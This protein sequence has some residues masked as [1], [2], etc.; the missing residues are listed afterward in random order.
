MA[1]THDNSLAA[2]C[3]VISS[4]TS[5]VQIAGIDICSEAIPLAEVFVEP[6][7][8][9]S[10]RPKKI[11]H[12]PPGSEPEGAAEG[13]EDNS[14][15][16]TALQVL[17]Q[18]QQLVILGEPGQGKTTVL[19]QYATILSREP[20]GRVP[21]LVELKQLREKSVGS[22]SHLDW[23][24]ARLPDPLQEHTR[25]HSECRNSLVKVLDKGRG[26]VLL[27]GLDELTLE[28]QQQVQ[29]LVPGLV[30]CGNQVVVSSR[31]GAY[32]FTPFTGF[33]PYYLQELTV[34]QIE[35]LATSLCGALAL[36]FGLG[37]SNP[38]VQCVMKASH[39]PAAALTRNPLLLSFLCLTAIERQ[40]RNELSDFPHSA[41]QLIRGCLDAVVAWH[42]R[43]GPEAWPQELQA[44]DI[45]RILGPLALAAY[46]N[47]SRIIKQEY[48]APRSTRAPTISS[49]EKEVFFNYL[50]PA[51]L[52]ERRGG[53]YAFPLE[54]LGEYFAA[55]AVADTDTPFGC[56]RDHLHDPAW[57]RVILLTAGCLEGGH[58]NFL[59]RELP[60]LTWWLRKGFSALASIVSALMPKGAKEAVEQSGG[61]L[62][63]PL[64]RWDAR[65]R[66]S[67]EF[68]VTS[69]FRHGYQLWPLWERRNHYERVLLRDLRIATRCLGMCKDPA[70]KLV[71]ELIRACLARW[72]EWW[73]SPFLTSIQEA[74]SA[75]G[76]RAFLVEVAR[77][78]SDGGLAHGALE[79][80]ETSAEQPEVMQCVLELVEGGEE[81][82]QYD[83]AQ[84]LAKASF[85]PSFRDRLLELT[86]NSSRT[87]REA[88]ILALKD[89]VTDSRIRERILAMLEDKDRVV[90][91]TAAYALRRAVAEPEIRKLM[92][93]FAHHRD[94]YFRHVAVG[95]LSRLGPDSEALKCILRLAKDPGDPWVQPE[96]VRAL[97]AVAENPHVRTCLRRIARGKNSL[98][99]EEAR[100][101]LRDSSR[102]APLQEKQQKNIDDVLREVENGYGELPDD[103]EETISCALKLT[104]DPW[105]SKYLVRSLRSFADRPQVARRLMQLTAYRGEGQPEYANA[106][107]R[108][109]A[110]WA[111]EV[112][113]CL[114][115]VWHHLLTLAQDQSSDM[116]EIAARALRGAARSVNRTMLEQVAPLAATS[117]SAWE[118]VDILVRA[119]EER[120]SSMGM[121]R[122]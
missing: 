97:S 65:S 101:L 7:L 28:A 92:L 107:V 63:G 55:R 58:A 116:N 25:Q 60:T 2:Y 68:F 106:E 62:E 37:D 35:L 75:P 40:T 5:S 21:V 41:A 19:R 76:V 85:N 71:R 54:T 18:S 11:Q 22:G 8:S 34:E 14:E 10:P 114:P 84:V 45:V 12:E 104:C 67:T 13:R 78:G 47:G 17:R 15:T 69:I 51:R 100:R 91:R 36:Q 33:A 99:A 108:T 43:R 23:L 70:P 59:I 56:I 120:K 74:A 32:R 4:Y 122:E 27:D 87:T 9:R 29:H 46:K 49:N 72:A 66:R 95:G 86:H 83:A 1:P 121:R 94:S 57:E 44:E 82:I 103:S 98:A 38:M 89:G 119:W 26:A 110:V 109:S 20:S 77:G 96:A 52:V 117:D 42:R 80:L 112:G 3:R 39:G 81:T 16:R 93:R 111:L 64:E 24:L 105:V 88:A 31:P 102:D 48:L 53:D 73:E 90:R 30:H 61:L 50:L 113:A 79:G 6:E 115:E 118:T